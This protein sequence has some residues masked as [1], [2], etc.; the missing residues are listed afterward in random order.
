MT[1]R[2]VIDIENDRL[3]K[4]PCSIVAYAHRKNGA[5]EAQ[6]YIENLE[7]ANQAKLARRFREIADTGWIHNE[8]NWEKLDGPIHEFKC[9]PTVRV[10]CFKWNKC[11]MLTHGF[12][13]KKGGRTP[14]RQIERAKQIMEEH[15]SLL[16]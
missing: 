8:H 14:K 1:N 10:L 5:K 13:K 16:Q 11:W 3:T 15:L 6:E 2:T 12:D 9:K 4:G 7:L